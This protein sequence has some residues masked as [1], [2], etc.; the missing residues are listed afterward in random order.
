[1][2]IRNGGTQEVR[3]RDCG[4]TLPELMVGMGV[5]ALVAGAIA[6]VSVGTLNSAGYQAR[7]SDAQVDVASAMA[8]VQDDLR[9]T[10]YVLDDWQLTGQLVFQQLTSGTSADSI[11]FVG[12]VNS[13][14]VTERIKYA[15]T[16]TSPCPAASSP[17]LMRTQD[18]WSSANQA[19]TA[20]SP[21]IAASN[22]T[23]F[24]LR[25]NLVDPCTGAV[26]SQTA[27]QVLS[28]TCTVACPDGSS[29]S[30]CTGQCTSFV[31]ITL[32]GTGTYKGRSVTRT[33]SSDVAERQGNVNSVCG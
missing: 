31:S 12:D 13:D 32:T 16:T 7:I 14:G 30:L 23:A 20:G 24:T 26:S 19:W 5:F 15:V 22:I 4:F 33:L 3:R 21:Q 18:N 2:M 28:P 6:S 25:F 27:A 1:M 29:T 17:C 9:L 8:L 10:G 11:T